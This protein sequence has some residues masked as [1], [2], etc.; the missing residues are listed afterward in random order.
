[1]A[2]TLTGTDELVF[3][4]FPIEKSETNADG[5]LVVYGKAT[6]GSV[7]ADEQIVQPAFAFA[8]I[9]AWQE[10]GANVRVQHNPQRDPA[11]KG[12]AVE[13][14]GNA[15]WVK[16][17]V[18]EPVAQKLVAK[19]VLTAY[20][21]GIARPVIERDV[22][23][24]ARGGIITGGQIVEI[25]LVDRPAN[26]SCGI[27]LVKSEGG[28]V[29]LLN[30]VFGDEDV[31]A[32]YLSGDAVTKSQNAVQERPKAPDL[33]ITFTP[34][35]L[36]KIMQHKVVESHY[37]ELAAKAI[38][39]AEYA[40]YK[41]DIDTATRRRLAG[42]GSALPDG[43]YPIE[44]ADDLHNAAVLARSGH[45]NVS[46]AKRLIARRARELDVPNPLHDSEES[47][48]GQCVTDEVTP[49]VVKDDSALTAEATPEVTKEPAKAK[50]PKKGKKLP[51][52]MND[53]KGDSDD[54]GDSS[55][56]ADHAHTDK[57]A[58]D[59]KTA[60]GAAE[61]A[62]MDPIP[63]P[64]ALQESPMPAGRKTPDTKSADPEHAAMLRFKAIGI[65]HDMGRLH[66]L[67][68]AAYDPQDTLKYHP[69][70]SFASTIDA[71]LWMRKAVDAACGPLERAY[72]L[73][74]AWKAVQVLKTADPAEL[75][76]YRLELHKAFR[77]A[78]PGPGTYPSPGAMSPQTFCR[79]VITAGQA[80]L[81]PGYGPPN[82]SPQ[83]ASSAPSA[84]SFDRPPLGA[85]HQSPS[86][87]HMKGDWEYPA[88]TGVPVNLS[89]AYI[90]KEKARQALATL[91]DHLA[92]EFPMACPMTARDP[93][94]QGQA[95]P[96]PAFEGKGQEPE[97]PGTGDTELVKSRKKML[98]K[99]G[100]K[101]MSG[102]LTL[103]EARAR[104][105]N[106]MSRKDN[107]PDVTKSAPGTTPGQIQE[108]QESLK[109]ANPDPDLIKSAITQALAPMADLIKTQ[110]NRLDEQQRVLEAIADQ[111]DPLTAAFSGLALN[112]VRKSRP[113]AVTQIAENAERTQ[114]MIQR[115]LTHTWRTSENPFEREAARAEL[116]KYQS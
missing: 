55:C 30:D 48:K 60:S 67:T 102:K 38:T 98:K 80:A 84:H 58:V 111:P 89:Y 68:C 97:H 44:N 59:P 107:A 26:K 36:M 12:I 94:T 35:D 27:A 24:K 96:V 61:A 99:L 82:S 101:V 65:D 3:A 108:L 23:G 116:D 85:G 8:A 71:D 105:G 73:T 10:T 110:Q 93:H 86:P 109:A 32:K 104:V 56:K 40:V 76:D 13:H 29:H 90:E 115:Q 25:S 57:C 114:Q 46:G 74:G 100:K 28:T 66:D 83:V 112:P 34:D 41:R 20:S 63:H 92:H 53:G 7:D 52:W 50:K 54:S 70:A 19:G 77:D 88:E 81:S 43:S 42:E 9:K 17:L 22:T 69:Y 21:V 106:S 2:V 49:D 87:S 78:N 33:S 79:P 18:V 47:E 4:S 51:P 45:G 37:D 1:V 113:A 64:D 91:H 11:G 6:D 31:I 95:R 15:T 16:A 103:D 14:D 39:D 5:D 62:D 72:E 75:N